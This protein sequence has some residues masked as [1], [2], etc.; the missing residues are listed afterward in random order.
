VEGSKQEWE[1]KLER[2]RSYNGM[3]TTML[4]T[5]RELRKVLPRHGIVTVG[6]GHPQSTTKQAFPVYEPRTHITSGSF[7]SMGFALPAA[8]GAKLAKPDTP[9][10][11]IIGDGDF[12]MGVQELA[13]CAMHNIPVTFLILN[14][15]GYI[16]IRDGQNHLMGR[17]IGSEFNKHAGDG[18]A[19][20]VDF[21]SLAKS[22]G[23][24]FA[25]KAQSVDDIG[26]NI[27]RALDSNAPAL[28]EVPI[29]RD[30]SIAAAEVVGWWDFPVLPTAT[31]AVKAD[32]KAGYAAEQHRWSRKDAQVAKPVSTS[33]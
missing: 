12:M 30:V 6:S 17:Q 32:Y 31:E 13:V 9:V 24:G 33:G 2:R 20:S 26:S 10:V 22:F 25:A 18:Q 19:Y 23:L 28:V 7:S 15:S 8:I 21:V 4:R 29:T 1:Q 5:L 16:S 14:N 3:P 11:C 27:K